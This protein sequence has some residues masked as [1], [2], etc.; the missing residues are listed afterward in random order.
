MAKSDYFIGEALLGTEENLAH[1]VM[2]GF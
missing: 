1:M 2:E